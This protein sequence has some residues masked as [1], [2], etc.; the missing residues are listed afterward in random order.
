MFTILALAATAGYK[1]VWAEEFNKAGR[2][3]PKNWTYEVGFIRNK[4]PQW[5]QPDNAW[6]EDGKLVIEG[7]RELKANPDYDPYSTDWRKKPLMA[8]LTS[9]CIKTK[10]LQAW[11]FGRFEARVKTKAEKGLWPAVWFLGVDKPWPQ[12][13]EIDLLEYYQDAF[14]ANTAYGNPAVW[15]AVKIP[16]KDISK[17]DANWDKQFH[18][19]R[20]DW[21]PEYIRLYVDDRLLNETDIRE[22]RNPDGFRPFHQPHYILINLALGATGGDTTHTQF[23][24]RIEVDWVRVYQQK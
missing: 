7:R 17:G 5:Y 19:W 3:D 21:T 15:D 13:G 10:G 6:V 22:V 4:E 11:T 1:L 2:P 20:M 16:Y 12:N 23:P 18:T 8:R 24:T 14:H 9:A